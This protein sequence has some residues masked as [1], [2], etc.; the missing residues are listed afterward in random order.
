[1]K[2]V[3]EVLEHKG[4]RVWTID[5]DAR[6]LDA[7]AQMAAKDV[8][9]LVVLEGARL[10][11]LISE[12]EYTRGVSL[13]GRSAQDTRVRDIMR[14][15]LPAVGLETDIDT[16]MTLMTDYR[17]RHLPVMRGVELVGIISIGDLVAAIIS[18]QQQMIER[19]EH[20]IASR[21]VRQ[22]TSPRV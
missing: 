4:H 16:C 17:I 8:G 20:F 3:R 18:G 22:P 2:T 9:A 19:L 13:I 10:V 14:T 11:G 7:I 15:R 21:M 5:A 1:M 12:R 6:V